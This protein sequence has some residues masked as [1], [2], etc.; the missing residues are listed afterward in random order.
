MPDIFGNIYYVTLLFLHNIYIYIASYNFYLF[1]CTLH[2]L[3]VGR[4]INSGIFRRPDISTFFKKPQ[5]KHFYII[6]NPPFSPYIL[7]F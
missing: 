2:R 3:I 7:R 1:N 4:E 5:Y 6:E